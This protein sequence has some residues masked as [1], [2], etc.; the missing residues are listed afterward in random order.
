LVAM[1][2][3]QLAAAHSL[4]EISGG[5]ARSPGQVSAPGA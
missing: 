2:F 3:C 5:L 4:R 1:L